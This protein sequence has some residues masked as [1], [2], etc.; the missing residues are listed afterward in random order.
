ML[1][2][3]LPVLGLAL[4]FC[5]AISARA[6]ERWETLEAIHWVENP[7]N[8]TRVG[9][10]GELGPYQFRIATWRMYTKKPFTLAVDRQ[11]S[12]RIA[13]MHYEWIKSNFER[14]GIDPTAYNIAMAWNSGLDAVLNGHIPA[15]TH[16]YAQQVSNIAAHLRQ[17][18]L[19]VND[20]TQ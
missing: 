4:A 11:E 17:Q 2:R 5:L 15:S 10:H 20:R 12:D 19:A 8:S 1:K 6:S 16:E 3:P 18:Q 14:N 13:I 9:S 7:H